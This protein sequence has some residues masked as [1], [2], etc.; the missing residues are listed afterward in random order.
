MV[1]EQPKSVA[2]VDRRTGDNDRVFVPGRQGT[3]AAVRRVFTE[4]RKKDCK[5]LVAVLML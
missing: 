2:V 3:G 5:C 4:A 1:D